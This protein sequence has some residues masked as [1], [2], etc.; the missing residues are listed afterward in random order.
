MSCRVAGII[1]GMRGLLIVAAVV[2]AC[3]GGSA[4][5]LLPHV[6]SELVDVY[7]QWDTDRYVGLFATPRGALRS[8]ESL[9]WLRDRLGECGAPEVMWSRGV[10]H[11]RFSAPCERGQLELDITLRRDGRI[12]RLHLGAA[13]V[14]AEQPLVGAVQRVVKALP[15][16]E[17]TGLGDR[18][19]GRCVFRRT[20]VVSQFAGL[21][22]LECEAGP[23]V[24]ELVVGPDGAPRKV[25]LSP[26]T[27]AGSLDAAS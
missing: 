6:A 27:V 17:Q 2:A 7:G 4:S 15:R 19:Y 23:A 25:R 13:G 10:L 24:L 5:E 11:T 14:A 12:D 3:S 1:G 20:W 16:V 8:G 26:S 21:F 9:A 18:S 22:H